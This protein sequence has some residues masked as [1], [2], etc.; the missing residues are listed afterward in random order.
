MMLFAPALLLVLAGFFGDFANNTQAL[1]SST[2]LDTWLDKIGTSGMV[3]LALLFAGSVTIL[4]YATSRSIR[5]LPALVVAIAGSSVLTLYAR[6]EHIDHKA[7]MAE[8]QAASRANLQAELAQLRDD[9]NPSNPDQPPCRLLSSS[10]CRVAD[11]NRRIAEI[12]D[13]LR[14]MRHETVAGTPGGEQAWLMKYSYLGIVALGVP[15]IN[16][17]LSSFCGFLLKRSKKQQLGNSASGFDYSGGNVVPMDR[18]KK[19]LSGFSTGLKKWGKKRFY[20]RSGN[21]RT[22][23]SET[24]TGETGPDTGL[25]YYAEAVRLVRKGVKPSTNALK[26]AGL[27]GRREEVQAYLRMMA[28]E[29]LLIPPAKNGGRYRVS[30]GAFNNVATG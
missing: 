4:G 26:Q 13:E 20:G 12:N 3:C 7:V 24:G 30:E 29:G 17:A 23:K 6:W 11:H 22:G 25:N 10:V 14:F 5:Y 18:F 9:L 28:N 19:K 21:P 16:G 8:T 2:R 15:L 27:R 1:V